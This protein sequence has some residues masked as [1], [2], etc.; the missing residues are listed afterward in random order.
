M[1]I[2]PPSPPEPSELEGDYRP[3]GPAPLDPIN[4]RVEPADIAYLLQ[5]GEAL[6]TTLD[7]QTL[8][9]R[10][11][12]LVRAV[13]H[14]QI[15]AILLLNDRTHELRTRFQIGHTP[16][17]E[18]M[19]VPVGKGV[20]G[21]VALTREPILLNDVSTAENYISANPAF[22]AGCAPDRKKPPYRRH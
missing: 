22:R 20:T 2:I 17:I 10:T 15:F 6:N 12:E 14:Y 3:A 9:N 5:L 16:E 1:A 19:R 11:S 13:I 7:L 18:R 4:T 21:Q 8:L